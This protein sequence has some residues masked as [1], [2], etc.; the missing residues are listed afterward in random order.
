MD[1][2]K[3]GLRSSQAGGTTCRLSVADLRNGLALLRANP[4]VG[5]RRKKERWMD[6]TGNGT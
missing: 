2:G 6:A 4:P 5:L 3:D 1:S